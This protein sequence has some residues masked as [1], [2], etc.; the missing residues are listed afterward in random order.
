ML[1]YALFDRDS[2][3]I[4]ALRLMHFP[5][6]AWAV[7]YDPER[8]R[9]NLEVNRS[10]IALLV[11]PPVAGVDVNSTWAFDWLPVLKERGLGR[12]AGI[13]DA[14]SDEADIVVAQFFRAAAASEKLKGA[15][16]RPLLSYMPQIRG[17]IEDTENRVAHSGIR[18]IVCDGDV[19]A[20][21][22]EVDR[23]V[24][25]V[26]RYVAALPAAGATTR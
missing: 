5:Q 10:M 15:L 11:P 9:A 7:W 25:D 23:F 2:E 26:D 6:A 8:L 1:K 19:A 24:A 4:D 20:L 18:T 21:T 22:R 16:P 14:A 3:C 13:P 17:L 12:H